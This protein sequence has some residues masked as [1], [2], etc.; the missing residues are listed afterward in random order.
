MNGYLQ[1]NKGYLMLGNNLIVDSVIDVGSSE[2][3]CLAIIRAVQPK[4]FS[5]V[6]Y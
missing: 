1:N 2:K 5:P 4:C 3:S 6:I